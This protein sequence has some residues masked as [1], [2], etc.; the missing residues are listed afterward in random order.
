[1]QTVFDFFVR[2]RSCAVEVMSGAG[3][4][5][6]GRKSR[7][8]SCKKINLRETVLLPSPLPDR[9]STGLDFRLGG[10]G[11]SD[12]NGLVIALRRF[13]DRGSVATGFFGFLRLASVFVQL[14]IL[15][16]RRIRN[17]RSAC[18]ESRI[19]ITALAAL[20]I[21]SASSKLT[22]R[23]STRSSTKYVRGHQCR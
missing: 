21:V 20:K 17:A 23:N 12:R 22:S 4:I 2:I 6:S 18:Y 5:V 13:I 3:V 15:R 14:L 11:S 8:G 9:L 16:L 7:P 10:K 1:M 19:A